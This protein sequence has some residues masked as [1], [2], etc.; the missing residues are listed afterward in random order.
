MDG[1]IETKCREAA[2]VGRLSRSFPN[3]SG[4]ID[5]DLLGIIRREK[6]TPEQYRPVYEALKKENPKLNL[7][8]VVYDRELDKNHWAGFQPFADVINLCVG[9]QTK[10]FSRLGHFLDQSEEIF[11]DK[12]INLVYR[13]RDFGSRPLGPVSMDSLEPHW[14]DIHK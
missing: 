14:K 10:D 5:D 13:L 8:I 4:A 2:T 3:V 1:K 7:W 6:I 12:P 9:N 11:P